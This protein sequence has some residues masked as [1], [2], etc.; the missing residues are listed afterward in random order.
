MHG[1]RDML[2]RISSFEWCAF[3]LTQLFNG[4]LQGNLVH[5]LEDEK[6]NNH[7]VYNINI[8]GD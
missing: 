3:S 8:N 6:L 1:K 7:L 2:M 4:L 5:D